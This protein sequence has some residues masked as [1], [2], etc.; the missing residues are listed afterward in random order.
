MANQ[1]EVIQ[2]DTGVYQIETTD[3]VQGGIGGL[4]NA[5]LLNLANRTAYLKKHVDDLEA[6]ATIPPTVAPLNSPNLTGTPTAPT[7]VLGDNST[8]ISTTAF[9]QGTV[10]GVTTKDVSGNINVTLTTVEAGAGILVFTGTLTGNI[11]VIVPTATKS[12]IVSNQ[13]TGAFTLTLKTAAGTGII[14]AQSHNLELW[15]DGANVVRSTDDFTDAALAGTPTAPTPT[16]GDNSTKVATTAFAQ[17][18][19]ND[20]GLLYAV[21]F[22]S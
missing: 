9:V 18:A 20:S 7:Q 17:Q 2:Y 13:T 8:K 19:A 5:P 15:G 10:N 4:D 11:A 3:P 14:V 21:I 22:G 12:W 6:G 1:P 16:T